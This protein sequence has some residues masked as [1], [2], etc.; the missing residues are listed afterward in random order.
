MNAKHELI[1]HAEEQVTLKKM[2]I[3]PNN[4]WQTPSEYQAAVTD[5]Y[6][7]LRTKLFASAI[8]EVD[9]VNQRGNSLADFVEPE[10]LTRSY[11]DTQEGRELRSQMHMTAETLSFA[12][13]CERKTIFRLDESL[14]RKLCSLTVNED[15]LK[16]DWKKRFFHLSDSY[17]FEFGDK[18]NCVLNF[19][20]K[21]EEHGYN[22]NYDWFKK[23]FMR[24]LEMGLKDLPTLEFEKLVA[25]QNNP[26]LAAYYRR[27]KTPECI[28]MT[29]RLARAM[30]DNFSEAM[31]FSW[32]VDDGQPD[33]ETHSQFITMGQSEPEHFTAYKEHYPVMFNRMLICLELLEFSHKREFVTNNKTFTRNM[34]KAAKDMPR[35]KEKSSYKDLTSEKIIDLPRKV[36]ITYNRKKGSGTHASP[37]GHLRIAHTRTYRHPRY[38][39]V[40]GKTTNIKQS[41]V[42][43]GPS[44]EQKVIYRP[45]SSSEAVKKFV[46]TIEKS[47]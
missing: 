38:V 30:M 13:A 44:G 43:G 10:K 24:G 42:N 5:L 34:R 41:L 25:N 28:N 14:S 32:F 40:L 36:Y 21:K 37:Q 12:K 19:N 8:K 15:I 18:W 29:K 16:L 26:K 45:K 1:D 31:T 20:S 7:E 22:I 35:K 33:S 11:S 23:S 27:M 2:N 17:I 47:L 4:K 39:N 9:M 6:E 3:G 46:K